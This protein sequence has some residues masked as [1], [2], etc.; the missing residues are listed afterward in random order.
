[1]R[2]RGGDKKVGILGRRTGAVQLG[3][4]LVAWCAALLLV[5][6]IRY[7][8]QNGWHEFTGLIR[9]VPL[10]L[11]AQMAIGYHVGLYQRRWRFGSFE[12]VKALAATA[13]ITA[14][15]VTL[16]DATYLRHLVPVSV[17]LGAGFIALV[18][19]L[20]PRYL[21]RMVVDQGL[22]PDPK[23]GA[24]RIIVIG[25]GEGGAQVITALLRNP[26]GQY[27]PVAILDDDP[28][29]ARL[30]ILGVRVRGTLDDLE[31]VSH[32][33]DATTVLLAIP[34]ASAELVRRATERCRA[35]GL[36]L[37]VLPQ[38]G[39]LHGRGVEATDIQLP[40]AADLLGRREIDTD[41]SSIA[42]YLNGRRVLVTGA[43]GSIGSEL[44]RQI[45][46]FGPAELIMLDRDESALH[47][48]QLSIEGRALLDR[49][50]LVVADIRDRGRLR[51]VFATWSPE[52]VFHAAALK[53]LPLL[54]LH[55]D[56][57][58]KTNV[59]GTQHLLDCAV[60]HGVSRFV[61][62][63]TDKAADPIS[64]LGYTK[65]VAERLTAD[66]A[67]RS[68]EGTYLSVRFGNVLGSRGALLDSLLTQIDNG[69]PVTI[70]HPDVTRYFM[71]IEEAVQLVV[72]AGAI[73]ESGQAL[74]LDMGEPVRILDLAE[75]LIA[76]GGVPVPTVFTGLRTGEKLHE[77]LLG[78]G[79]VDIRP[80]HPLVSHVEVPP[81]A[82]GSL[83]SLTAA[84][85]PTM[86]LTL[87][88]LCQTIDLTE[89]AVA[90][91]E[92]N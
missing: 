26:N 5:L 48:V 12:E 41:I 43:G 6:S 17:P 32:A 30:R 56:E 19:M 13:S 21:W 74:V 53:H 25:A 72:Q 61:N 71:T 16:I 27:L 10:V 4:D 81:L 34:S 54:E 91:V 87:A 51:E 47:A 80:R 73:G 59:L 64:V 63:S 67:E 40:T 84:S 31:W 23:D 36:K 52:V 58:V 77:V 50:N 11:I 92:L 8:F 37:L 90:P 49:P 7:D 70:T 69:G 76:L 29:K 33:V 83:V 14:V 46:R 45:N 68:T 22:R 55:P 44:C 39:R 78:A 82:V 57:A 86:K 20:G 28:A 66:A 9:V 75:Q 60:A 79:E 3:V 38:V 62:I 1:V 88:E 18:G 24:E 89:A 35:S 15:V 42:S 85:G 65:R 2:T